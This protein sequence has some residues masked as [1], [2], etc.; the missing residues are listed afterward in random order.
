MARMSRIPA[1][2]D[3]EM[4]PA[5]RAFVESLLRRIDE[6]EAQLGK[7]PKLFAAAQFAAPACEAAGRQE[8]EAKQGPQA[9][10]TAGP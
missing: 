5:V 8:T 6:L 7:A 3:A 1:E 10:R 9:G 4:T 2:L